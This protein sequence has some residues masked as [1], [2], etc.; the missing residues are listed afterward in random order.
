MNRRPISG[1]WVAACILA[2]AVSAAAAAAETVEVS[3]AD[4]LKAQVDLSFT[5]A[6]LKNVLSS[7][8]KVYG[9]NIVAPESVTGTVTLTLKGVTLE[10]GLRQILKLN[11]FGFVTREN[12][13]EVVRLEE[14][15]VAEVLSVRY[16]NPD[17]AL[18]FLQPMASENAILKVDEA[19][20]G[21]LVS[22]FINKIEAMKLVLARIDQPPRQ[23][24]IESKLIDITHTDLDNLGVSLSSVDLTIPI[25]A[26]SDPISLASAAL[27]LA[28]PSSSLTSD[29][30][31]LT[32]GRGDDTL[33]AT[34]NALIRDQRVKVIATPSVLTVNNVEAKIIIGE[35]FPIR[36]QTQTTT[37]T[38]ETT[39]FVD[40]GT[41]LRVTPRIDPSGYIQMHIHPEVSSVSATLDEGPRITTREADTTV[42][43]RDGQAVVIAGLLQEDETR[44]RGRIPILGHLPFV[45]LL[46]QNR[47]KDYDQKELVVIITPRIVDV[48]KETASAK[49][50][51]EVEEVADR[52]EISE[53]F[54]QARALENRQTLQARQMPDLLRYRKAASLYGRAVN[55]F[56][57]HPLAMESLWYLGRIAR[58]ELHDLDRAEAAYE[59]LL[60][61]FPKAN[62]HLQGA[63]KQIRLIQL[64]RDRKE[65]RSSRIRTIDKPR[66][67]SPQ[68]NIGF[69]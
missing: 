26:G 68:T 55:R 44:I 9:L 23:V 65:G 1:F 53:L 63:K 51:L 32:V 28:G 6:D 12:I 27:D 46:F 38:L 59:R 25:K 60:T 19:S 57:A 18:E 54:S 14:E 50:S 31:A 45:G 40:V 34:I 37:G 24:M 22:D 29:E 10:E 58:E 67:N 16:L 62:P 35:K 41:T 49:S 4:R 5:N 48:T 43:V 56:P 47:S 8:A 33:T 30:V 66:S 20:N 17:T 3:Q 69:R 39:R 42:Y 15:R 2:A 13:I 52:L 7:L 21:I 61:Q 64:E 11:G 36:E